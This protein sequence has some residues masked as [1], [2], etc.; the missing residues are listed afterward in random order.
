M[1]WVAN[2]NLRK[3]FN[4]L[5]ANVLGA[6][7]SCFLLGVPGVSYLKLTFVLTPMLDLCYGKRFFSP[8]ALNQRL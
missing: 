8:W 6:R 7:S 5:V 2:M 3:N 4:Y 1:L